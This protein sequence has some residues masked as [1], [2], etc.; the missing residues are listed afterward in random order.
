M[1]TILQVSKEHLFLVFELKD[2]WLVKVTI[3][4]YYG[5][6]SA[7]RGKVHEN[8][9]TKVGRLREVGIFYS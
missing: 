3:A 5:F 2:S 4:I 1:A 7:R 9:C 8:D 6:Y